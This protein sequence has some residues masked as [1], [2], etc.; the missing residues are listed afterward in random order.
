[1]AFEW[2]RIHKWEDNIES[3]VTDA[4]NDYVMEFYGVSEVEELTREM[5]DEI[6]TF[7]NEELN[8]YS[9]MQVGFSNLVSSWESETGND[10]FIQA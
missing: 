9:L 6:D 4:V 8:E 1:M 5:I 7:R 3:Q 2:P 10:D